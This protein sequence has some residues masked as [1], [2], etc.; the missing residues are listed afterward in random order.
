MTG[1]DLI[2]FVG[3]LILFS[4]LDIVT[5]L[6]FGWNMDPATHL[7]MAIFATTIAAIREERK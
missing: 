5:T 7:A 4:V 6:A 2:R 3:F 1:T